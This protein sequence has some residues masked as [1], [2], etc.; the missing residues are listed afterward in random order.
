M[1]ATMLPTDTYF[2]VIVNNSHTPKLAKAVIGHNA[3]NTPNAAS[4]PLPPLKP[5]KHV[6]LCPKI[7][8]K[9]ATK[10]TQDS[11]EEFAVHI[12]NAINGPKKPFSKSIK[13]TGR[14]GRQPRTL[15]VFVKPAFFEP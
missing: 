8:N 14:A 9:P 7:T 3:K 15:N 6:K 10:G 12:F 4:T 5:A 11:N 1:H 13:T 2:V